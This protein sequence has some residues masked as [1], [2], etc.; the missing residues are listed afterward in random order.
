MMELRRRFLPLSCGLEDF[1]CAKVGQLIYR[2]WALSRPA[3]SSAYYC[4]NA[5]QTK[6]S[7]GETAGK[8]S[9]NIMQTPCSDYK[10]TKGLVYFARMLDKIRLRAQGRLP[11]EYFTGV[12]DPTF[13][14]AR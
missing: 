2:K 3:R 4:M 6:N 5:T 14:D 10:K 13:F 7:R 8:S 1:I 12:E 9:S 11:E